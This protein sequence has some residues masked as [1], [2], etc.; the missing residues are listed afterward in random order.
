[1]GLQRYIYRPGPNSASA[2][3]VAEF[4]SLAAARITTRVARGG[5]RRATIQR[6]HSMQAPAAKKVTNK[7]TSRIEL[8]NPSR[9][10]RVPFE[11]ALIETFGTSPTFRC[12]RKIE[13]SFVVLSAVRV[14][15]QKLDFNRWHFH[16]YASWSMIYE[17]RKNDLIYF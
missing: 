13:R 2:R 10:H 8:F 11:K 1:M 15:N 3:L 12:I 17:N 5:R 4:N 9:G 7:A 14:Q 16:V 6:A